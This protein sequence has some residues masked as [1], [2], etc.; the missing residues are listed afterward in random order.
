[1]KSKLLT[2]DGEKTWAIIFAAGDEPMRGLAKF[3]RENH[4]TAA[5]F[6]A[7]GAFQ[8]VTFA[9]FDWEK[10]S[11]RDIPLEEQVEVLTMAGDISLKD[12]QPAVHAH[13]IAGRADGTTRGGHLKTAIVRPTLEVMLAESPAV[14]RRKFDEKSGLALIDPEAS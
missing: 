10:K 13:L 7:I 6:T 1:M 9:Y 11:Y 8:R 4:L 5:R 12:G 14:L 3:A 2:N